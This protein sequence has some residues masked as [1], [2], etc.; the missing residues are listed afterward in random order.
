MTMQRLLRIEGLPMF[1]VL[2]ALYGF[3][4]LTAPNVFTGRRIYMSFLQTVPPMLVLALGL[5]LVI[6]AGEIDLSFA[7]TVAFSGLC[8]AWAY[9]NVDG[10]IGVWVALVAALLAGALVGYVNGLLI[11]RVGVPSI[12]AT[13]A[14]GFFWSGVTVLLAGGLSW[15]I[16]DIQD[17]LAHSIF[18]GRL[19]DLVPAQALWSLGLA[20]VLW[21]VLNR[22]RFGEAI[23]FI[24][25]NV[26]VARVVGINVAATKIKLFTLNGVIAGFA[27]VLLTIELHTFWPTQGQGY[28][29]LALAAVFIG[30]TSIAGGEG[31]VVGTLFGAYIIGSLEAG[32]VA[33]GVDGYW[34]SLITGLVMGASV[35]LNIVISGGS[36]ARLTE[37]LRSWGSS[38]S[39]EHDADDLLEEASAR[40]AESPGVEP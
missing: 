12:M 6:T 13:L 22:H 1:G 27:G 4:I 25:D 19:F 14:A 10:P 5:T 17:D 38:S 8:F 2:V 23:M 31:T 21:F 18:T 16:R 29:L 20:V 30:G 15:S 33:T 26:N 7:S 3:F 40:A 9:R 36:L 39:T 34:T 32:V 37:S 35:V 11:A 28:L 24:G